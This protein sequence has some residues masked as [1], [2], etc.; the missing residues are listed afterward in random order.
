MKVLGMWASLI[1]LSALGADDPGLN[2]GIPISIILI[3]SNLIGIFKNTHLSKLRW[4]QK[5]RKSKQQ[6]NSDQGME[7]ES[8]ENIILLKLCRGRDSPHHSILEVEQNV[9]QQAFGKILRQEEFLQ[10][11]HT[12]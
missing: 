8:E 3:L 2:P 10:D 12:S 5:P 1:K 6:E 9:L 4:D 11:Q 7:S